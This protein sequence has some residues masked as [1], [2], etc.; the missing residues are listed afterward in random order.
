M[1]K[2]I[3]FA[4]LPLIVSL[5]MSSC[6]SFQRTAVGTA[7]PI[8]YAASG[9]IE[10]E[11]N[12]QMFKE[13]APANLKLMEAL[14]YVRPKDARMLVSLTKGYGGYA[15]A[16]NETLWLDDHLAGRSNSQHRDQAIYNYSKSIEYGFRYLNQRGVDLGEMKRAIRSEGGIVEYL[17]SKLSASRDRDVEV[18]LFTAQSLAAY[19]NFHRTD[20][21]IVGELPVAKGMFDWVCSHHPDINFGAC[22]IFYGAYEAG[23]PAMLGGNPEKGK[24]YFLEAMEKWPANW[25]TAVAY[26]QYYLIPMSDEEGFK[27]VFGKYYSK[28]DELHKALSWHPTREASDEFSEPKLGVY[29]AM[30]AERL[31][32]INKYKDELF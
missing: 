6:S 8:F 25:L 32:I 1:P 21:I 13:G 20:M 29:Q 12:W 23:R 28:V 18:V 22:D 17:N 24:R 31:K 14:L 27:E 10:T 7:T 2:R 16:V 9:E 5:F 4:L 15:F 30:A 19:I 11:K 3:S 26:L